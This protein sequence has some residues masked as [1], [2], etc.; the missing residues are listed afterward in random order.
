MG[1]EFKIEDLIFKIEDGK[2]EEGRTREPN[3]EFWT[4]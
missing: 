3:K 4:E 1:S 2:K